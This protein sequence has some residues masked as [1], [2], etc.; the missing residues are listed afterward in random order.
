MCTVTFLP[1]DNRDFIIT[2]NRDESPGRD[3]FA[4]AL[5][6]IHT[7]PVYFPKDSRAGG[8]WFATAQNG[9][10]VVLLNGADKKHTRTLPYRKSRGL[11]ML[12]YY[13]YNDTNAYARQYNFDNIEPFTL[14]I[15]N[16]KQGSLFQ[17]MWDGDAVSLAEKDFTKPHI[18]S[19]ATLYTEEARRLRRLWFDEW[20]EK[21]KTYTV[22]NISN[23][24]HF[25]GTGDIYNDI[26]M[27]R[28]NRVRTVSITSLEKRGGT[29][30]LLY[31]ELDTQQQHTLQYTL[32]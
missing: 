30:R 6:T 4:P 8:T 10:T 31:E 22:E 24:H 18:W 11:V 29:A 14:V 20:L 7:I 19:S 12:D 17:L 1:L 32:A 16:A 25:G 13:L 26:V 5:Y 15:A 28:D 27:N 23:F 2:S 3:T 21:N 9:H